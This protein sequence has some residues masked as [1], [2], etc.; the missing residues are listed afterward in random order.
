[1][2]LTLSTGER[3]ENWMKP[4]LFL[5]DS[6]PLTYSIIIVWRPSVDCALL[7]GYFCCKKAIFIR[8]VPH[9]RPGTELGHLY[10]HIWLGKS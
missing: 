2:I 6:K 1:M 10:T 8:I 3:A 4:F 5:A 7:L 9:S